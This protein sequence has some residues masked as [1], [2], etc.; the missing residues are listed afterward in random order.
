MRAIGSI[1][2]IPHELGLEIVG[3]SVIEEQAIRG[4]SVDSQTI[5]G[6]GGVASIR[7]SIDG[8]RATGFIAGERSYFK[9]LLAARRCSRKDE[10]DSDSEAFGPGLHFLD[11]PKQRGLTNWRGELG[12]TPESKPRKPKKVVLRRRCEVSLIR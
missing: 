11:S 12:R 4:R 6:N 1:V 9:P 8:V 3:Q 5:D 2:V 10:Q 7:E